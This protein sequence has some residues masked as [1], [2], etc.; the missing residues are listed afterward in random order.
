MDITQKNDIENCIK[1]IEEKHGSID[2]LI[3]NAGVSL[4]GTVSQTTIDV[5]RKMMEINY[6][7]PVNLVKGNFHVCVLSV[8]KEQWRSG[9]ALDLYPRES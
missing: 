9:R 8:V 5:H 1:E 6:F 3:S 7:G 4:R 2:I